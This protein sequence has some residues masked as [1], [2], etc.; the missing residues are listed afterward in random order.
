MIVFIITNC[1]PR[2]YCYN[3]WDIDC[4]KSSCLLSV[5]VKNNATNANT[6]KRLP[7]CRKNN[8]KSFSKSPLIPFITSH[9]LST[10]ESPDR[11]IRFPLQFLD[12]FLYNT[13]SH[14]S[15][16]Q[17]RNFLFSLSGY[18]FYLKPDTVPR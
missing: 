16:R 12:N 4:N 18:S 5:S 2:I 11:V 13:A 9:L 15:D 6:Q 3:R 17:F 8:R 14:L 1:I 7:P 10:S